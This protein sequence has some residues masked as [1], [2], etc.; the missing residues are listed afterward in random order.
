[1]QGGA[2]LTLAFETALDVIGA[3]IAAAPWT[4]A[5]WALATFGFA[6]AGYH[7]AEH[8]GWN[9][10]LCAMGAIAVLAVWWAL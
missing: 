2:A 8:S 3:G 6:L 4:W 7:V 1:M 9:A 5:A 10:A